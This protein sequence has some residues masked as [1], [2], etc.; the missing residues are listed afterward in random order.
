MGAGKVRNWGVSNFDIADME[1]RQYS[2][3]RGSKH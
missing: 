3:R 1:E 2:R